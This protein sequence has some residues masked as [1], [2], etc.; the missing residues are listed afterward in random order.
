MLKDNQILRVHL[1]GEYGIKLTLV[2]LLPKQKKIASSVKFLA[3]AVLRWHRHQPLLLFNTILD[4]QREI[5]E[6]IWASCN[7]KITVG[8]KENDPAKC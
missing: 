6:G 3:P 7:E 8:D 2:E 1:A 5:D 4:M